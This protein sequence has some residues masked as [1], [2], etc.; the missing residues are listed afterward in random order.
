MQRR[1]ALA[2]SGNFVVDVGGLD[3]GVECRKR[4]C[5]RDTTGFRRRRG[6]STASPFSDVD[7]FGPWLPKQVRR[8]S[9]RSDEQ[10]AAASLGKI[11]PDLDDFT[12]LVQVASLNHTRVCKRVIPI[13]ATNEEPG[14]HS[15][16]GSEWRVCVC[17]T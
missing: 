1:Q 12:G 11:C 14:E 6:A 13:R 2:A 5:G 7:A 9:G 4:E 15:L 17:R 16:Q 10:G 8:D 3:A